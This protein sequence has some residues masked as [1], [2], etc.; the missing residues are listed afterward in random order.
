LGAAQCS[1]SIAINR[2]TITLL[3]R[4][5]VVAALP[6]S[7]PSRRGLRLLGAFVR[8]QLAAATAAAAAGACPV[9]SSLSSIA[10][11]LRGRADLSDLSCFSC[12]VCRCGGFPRS[13]DSESGFDN[14]ARNAWYCVLYV[15]LLYYVLIQIITGPVRTCCTRVLLD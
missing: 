8:R 3:S 2:G 5:L 12:H 11:A 10:G 7:T 14:T 9:P 4:R 13:V 15:F 6:P 1:R